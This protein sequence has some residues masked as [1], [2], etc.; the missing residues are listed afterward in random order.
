MRSTIFVVKP[1]SDLCFRHSAVLHDSAMWVFGGM[2][3]LQDRADFW[4]FDFSKFQ[5]MSEILLNTADP[6]F[7]C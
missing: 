7:F 1:V 3:D 6:F 5:T 4:K 2:T